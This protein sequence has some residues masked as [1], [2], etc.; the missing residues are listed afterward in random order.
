[1]DNN[2]TDAVS[3]ANAD[4]YDAF[5]RQDLDLMSSVWEYG[6]R[7]TCTHPGWPTLHGTGD[8]IE[9]YSSIFGGPQS[10]QVILTN[11]HVM[12]ESN[13]AYV[14]VDENMVDQ[15]GNAAAT[16]ALNVFVLGSDERWHMVVHHGSPIVSR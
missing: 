6:A 12:V 7:S 4:Y 1:M 5:E 11:E 16:A 10:L 3:S 8:I 15:A 14:S 9:S 13:F 2:P